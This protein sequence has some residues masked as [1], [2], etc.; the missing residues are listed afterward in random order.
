MRGRRA[1]RAPRDADEAARSALLALLDRDN[2][3][4]EALLTDAANL[5]SSGVEPYLAL[6]RFYRMRGEI[7]RAIRVHQNLLLRRDLDPEQTVTAIADLATDFRQGGFLQRAIASY[8]EVLTR[9]PSHVGALRA[10]VALLGDVR[11]YPRALEMQRRLAKVDPSCGPADEARLLVDMAEAEMAAGRG[12]AA[13]RSVRRALR[14]NPESVRAWLVSGALEAE[15]GRHRAALAA[16]QK[17]PGLDRRSGALVYPRIQA[18]FAAQGRSAE[19]ETYLRGLLAGREDDAHARM[20]LARAI[21]ARGDVEEA[22]AELQ[23]LLEREPESLE[24]RGVLGRLLLSERRDAEA[25]KAYAELLDVLERRGF[26]RAER[27]GP[28]RE[29]FA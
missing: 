26:L 12:D 3:R 1:P 23:R 22:L 21:A 10:L 15:R 9:D 27:H 28:L 11:D 8:E 25:A 18:A 5:D 20:A 29:P 17:I 16:W 13:R 4:A 24:A 14:R 2:E 7:G 19:F 6:A